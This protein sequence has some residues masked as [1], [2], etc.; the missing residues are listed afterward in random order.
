MALKIEIEAKVQQALTDISKLKRAL[1]EVGAA[2]KSLNEVADKFSGNA[3]KKMGAVGS[4]FDRFRDNFMAMKKDSEMRRIMDMAAKHGFRR[5]DPLSYV[6]NISGFYANR[7]KGEIAQAKFAVNLSG[8]VG[9][10]NNITPDSVLGGGNMAAGQGGGGGYSPGNGGN[11]SS[12]DGGGGFAWGKNL[13]WAGGMMLGLAG[14]NSIRQATSSGMNNTENER[15]ST[16]NIFRR[17]SFGQPFES[18]TTEIHALSR[19]LQLNSA[20]TAKLADEYVRASGSV[21]GF[22]ESLQTAVGF[23]RGFGMDPGISSRLMGQASLLGY[24][25]KSTQREFAALLAHT[26]ASSHMFARSEQI[27]EDMVNHLGNVATREGRTASPTEMT[28]YG[29]LMGSLYGNHAMAGGGG[30]SFLQGLQGLGAGGDLTKEMFAWQSLGQAAGFDFIKM[31][32]LKDANPFASIRDILGS[33]PDK[34][35]LEMMWPEVMRQAAWLPG[36]APIEDKAAYFL[37]TQTGMNMN[38][39]SAGVRLLNGK[40]GDFGMFKGWLESTTKKGLDTINPEAFGELAKLYEDQDMGSW[41]GIARLYT[42]GDKASDSDRNKL[43]QLLDA[44]DDA[45]LRAIL[46][47]IVANTGAPTNPAEEARDAEAKLATALAELVTPLNDLKVQVQRVADFLIPRADGP[48]AQNL[49]DAADFVWGKGKTPSDWFHESFPGLSSWL[50][51]DPIRRGVTGAF[52]AVFP[53]AGA[54]MDAGQYGAGEG[55]QS[56]KLKGGNLARDPYFRG[57]IAKLEKERGIPAGMLAKIMMQESS[58]RNLGYHFGDGAS[59]PGHSDYGLFGIK[60]DLTG[61]SPGYGVQPL[62]GTSPEEQARF[63]AD[64]LAAAI[65]AT[66][67]PESGVAAYHAG[68]PGYVKGDPESVAAGN[69]YAGKVNRRSLPATGGSLLS[70]GKGSFAEFLQSNANLRSANERAR[71]DLRGYPHNGCA[72]Y[73]SELLR[74][75]GM[76][77]GV[78]PGAQNLA[79]ALK[80]RGWE[81]IPLGKQRPGDIGVTKDMGAGLPGA[82][83]VYTVLGVD[84]N[85]PDKMNITDNQVGASGTRYASGKG[86]KTPTE[87]FLRAPASSPLSDGNRFAMSRVPKIDTISSAFPITSDLANAPKT[88]A[89]QDKVVRELTTPNQANARLDGH[90]TLDIVMRNEKGKLFYQRS[91][92]ALSEPQVFGSPGERKVWS[93]TATMPA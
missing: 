10:A 87:Y 1:N 17:S 56:R 19:V 29:A 8:G 18:L 39:G 21:G 43:Q 70:G 62:Q 86:G 49:N 2:G 31:E 82:D 54:T 41:R 72:T 69:E 38:L 5:D 40:M 79:D 7:Q 13:K 60:K 50:D 75:S 89:D 23:G 48:F 16:E 80:K 66:G 90:Y 25:D 67:G 3:Y 59:N 34:T 24:S 76:D 74:G 33:G 35:K 52:D 42:Q 78:I 83:H 77:I 26:I 58:G 30:Q 92:L 11:G 44:N 73:A 51:S 47:Q 85:N 37:K 55:L 64:Y 28:S 45:G 46:P 36:D 81:R 71:K 93:D 53:P 20:E 88:P 12:G 61:K 6:N 22:G 32:K 9:S 14:I 84:P 68:I 65:K 27:M 15:I 63:A 91:G 4:D 57:Y